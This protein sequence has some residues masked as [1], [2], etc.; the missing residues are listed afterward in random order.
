MLTMF[1][2]PLHD[3]ADIH[4]LSLY[5]D[6]SDIINLF[7][8]LTLLIKFFVLPFYFDSIDILHHSYYWTSWI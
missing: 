7:F 4:L 5:V 8:T 1:V 3:F 6:S 2:L